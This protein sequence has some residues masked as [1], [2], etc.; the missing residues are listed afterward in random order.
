MLPKQLKRFIGMF[1]SRIGF[2]KPLTM[3]ITIWMQQDA[4]QTF[5]E[6][7]NK[8]QCILV[9]QL[10]CMKPKIASLTTK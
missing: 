5:Y 2:V 9:I 6:N 4:S 3:A 7:Y 8:K 10:A 1:F